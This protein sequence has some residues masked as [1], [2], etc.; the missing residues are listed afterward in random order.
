MAAQASKLEQQRQTRREQL[1]DI[2][3]SAILERIMSK[4]TVIL[5]KISSAGKSLPR[6]TLL[7]IVEVEV[8][9]AADDQLWCDSYAE[10]NKSEQTVY[11]YVNDSHWQAVG[12]QQWKY[13]V[14][15]CAK[16]CGLPRSYL[17][18]PS[19]MNLLYEGVA[20]NVKDYKPQKILRDEL[21]LNLADCTLEIK[22]DGTV[23]SREHRRD[24]CFFYCLSYAYNPK[25]E[26]PL[27]FAYL[28]RTLP[29]KESQQ[30]L[31]EFLGYCLMRDHRFEKMLWL[32]GPGGNGKSTLIEVILALLGDMNVS[33]VPLSLLTTGER[34]QAL[35]E[36][37]LLNASF[38][39]G[40]NVNSD[41]LKQMVSGEPLTIELK[42]KNPRQI[43]DYGK[44]LMASNHLPDPEDSFA[45][46]RR[47]I[48]L[49]FDTIISDDEKDN[50]LAKKL[51]NECPGILN[52]VIQALIDLLKRNEFCHCA[53]SEKAV[54]EYKLQGDSVRLFV[55]E[56]C[57][58]AAFSVAASDLDKA[59]REYCLA[60]G[61]K[62]L[63][64]NKFYK[65]LEAIGHKPVKYQ[66]NIRFNLKLREL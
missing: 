20:F 64:R 56:N 39:S 17:M 29:D 8:Q 33:T 6:Q 40:R 48:I 49:N 7:E 19:F 65:R 26:S 34:K 23:V 14:D 42:Y 25:A 11:V 12:P 27:F 16:R 22:S 38:E 9:R 43:T 55:S 61:M 44:I 36:H 63:G 60:T 1:V 66:N 51:K 4:E 54:E 10:R 24:D 13:F 30:T 45:F 53:A 35:F 2:A 28:D 46:F 21:W 37:K 32:V 47:L 3:L 15:Q 50:Q 57:E 41:V 5:D 52:W 18:T 59:Y 31:A 58:P 62:Y